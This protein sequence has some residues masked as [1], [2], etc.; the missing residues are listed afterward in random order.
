[1][2]W[3]V[4]AP[5]LRAHL[6]SIILSSKYVNIV[7]APG[8]TAAPQTV[9]L[10]TNEHPYQWTAEVATVRGGPWLSVTPDRGS[11]NG[12]F[13]VTDLRITAASA[14]L[15]EGVYYGTITITA[16]ATGTTPVAD[17]TPQVIEVAL[18]VTTSGQ[19]APGLALAPVQ[20]AFEGVQGSGRTQS[21]NVQVR[22]VGGGTLS[23]T[24]TFAPDTGGAWLSLN[25]A[26][27][28]NTGLL[29]ATAVPG[30]LATGTYTGRLT[31]TAAGAANSPVIPVTYRVRDPLPPSL[32]LTP[33]SVTFTTDAGDPIPPSQTL[34]ITNGG[35]GTLAWQVAATTFN[36]GPWLSATPASGRGLG[37]VTLSAQAGDLGPGTYAGRVTVSA[38]RKSVV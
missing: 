25:P 36:G 27:G 15:G 8:A 14:S 21:Q 29:V 26:S 16:P 18:T 34:V 3:L 28:T 2:V 17:N 12:N 33:A 13:E 30:N 11:F 9:R 23:W 38:D 32:V 37:T 6:P 10:G 7:V 35:E 20:L 24:A 19:A 31:F 1:M 4:V 22:N 5:A